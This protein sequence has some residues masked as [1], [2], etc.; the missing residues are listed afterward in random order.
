MLERNINE[1]RFYLSFFTVIYNCLRASPKLL[2]NTSKFG[3]K[4]HSQNKL[5]RLADKQFSSCRYKKATRKG[6]FVLLSIS[7]YIRA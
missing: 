6:R 5:I 3:K 7:A 1:N 4:F 2:V